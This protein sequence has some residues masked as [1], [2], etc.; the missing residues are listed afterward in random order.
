MFSSH[1]SHPAK[2]HSTATQSLP[3]RR[4]GQE[5]VQTPVVPVVGCSSRIRGCAWAVQERQLAQDRQLARGPERPPTPPAT[6][7]PPAEKPSPP[8]QQPEGALPGHHAR[9]TLFNTAPIGGPAT[10][11]GLSMGPLAAAHGGGEGG[12]RGGGGHSPS[13]SRPTF[14]T[15]SDSRQTVPPAIPALGQFLEVLKAPEPRLAVSP[16]GSPRGGSPAA[17]APRSCSP[18]S[19]GHCGGSGG[20]GG[21]GDAGAVAVAG[22]EMAGL[23]AAIAADANAFQTASPVAVLLPP[24]THPH[25]TR[26]AGSRSPSASE[27]AFHP[28]GLPAPPPPPDAPLT[29]GALLNDS[30][31]A[32]PTVL[33]ATAPPVGEA[34]GDAAAAARANGATAGNGTPAS[35]CGDV[36]SRN[37]AT[38]PAADSAP[39]LTMEQKARLLVP[40]HAFPPDCTPLHPGHLSR[41]CCEWFEGRRSMC[42]A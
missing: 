27:P 1:V 12:V 25:G 41:D 36:G 30:A 24:P 18:G 28:D 38:A 9:P 7:P 6:A 31:G 3:S 10:G 32:S 34:E 39:I 42:E 19:A 8:G 15:P 17:E 35:D 13:D 20:T 21:G 14:S 16:G 26:A 5:S 29:D 11:E 33:P 40:A 22:S 4:W 2:L 37:A 23:E